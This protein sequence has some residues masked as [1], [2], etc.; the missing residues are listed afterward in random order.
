MKRY[1]ARKAK[2]GQL[3]LYYGKLPGDS[4]DIVGAW[5]GEGASSRDS[6][7]L[8]N[9]FCSKRLSLA[10]SDEDRKKSGNLPYF[11]D[12]N[13]IDELTDRGYDISTLKFSI[14][15]KGSNVKLRGCPTTEGEADK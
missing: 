9:A 14:E 7:L 15:L 12:K 8:M 11:W 2:P 13:L 4:P 3:L 6:K 5:G 10:F 1:R